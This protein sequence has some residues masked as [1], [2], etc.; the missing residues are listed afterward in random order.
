MKHLKLRILYF[1]SRIFFLR[2]LRARIDR[3]MLSKR[4]WEYQHWDRVLPDFTLQPETRCNILWKGR[5][6]G[7]TN[8]VLSLKNKYEGSCFIVGTGPS[9]NEI[10]FSLLKRYPC[11]G[12]NGAILKFEEYKFT[13]DF[14]T[15][16]T[17][18]F[19][20]NRPDLVRKA[21]LSGAKCFFPF[22]GIGKISETMPDV[23]EESNLYHT[24]PLNQCYG[25]P[26][27]GYHS[28]FKKVSTDMDFIVSKNHRKLTDKVGFSKNIN[29]G[30]FHGENIIYTAIQHAYYLG[31]RRIFIVGMDLNYSNNNARFY[32][33]GKDSRPSWSDVSF[34][35]SIL[36]CFKIIRDLINDNVLEVYNLSPSSKLPNEVIQKITLEEALN[37]K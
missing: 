35:R 13:P 26:R 16:T 37:L 21:I 3:E 29:K 14:Y 31:F 18:D 33:K 12:V 34:D 28:F 7:L 11:F 20:E 27:Q 9:V 24:D 23:I 19:F 25:L 1:L 6:L 17:Y 22:W 32:E 30:Y 4:P 2:S 10:D 5:L 15:I 8:S 36:P